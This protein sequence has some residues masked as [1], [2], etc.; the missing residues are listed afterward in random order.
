ML[1]LPN[2]LLLQI[3]AHSPSIYFNM[4]LTCKRIANIRNTEQYFIQISDNS[5]DQYEP[6]LM[7][8]RNANTQAFNYSHGASCYH[9]TCTYSYLPNGSLHSIN[10]V[11]ALYNSKHIHNWQDVTNTLITNAWYKHDMLHRVDNPAIIASVGD[12]LKLTAWYENGKL[13]RNNGPA[14]TINVNFGSTYNECYNLITNVI[15]NHWM[16]YEKNILGYIVEALMIENI[17]E[18]SVYY[19]DDIFIRSEVRCEPICERLYELPKY[20]LQEA[21]VDHDVAKNTI[22]DLTLEVP[23]A[24]A[25]VEKRECHNIYEYDQLSAGMKISGC[26]NIECNKS[27]NYLVALTLSK[28]Q[29]IQ[30]DESYRVVE[31]S[32]SITCN[33]NYQLDE[34]EDLLDIKGLITE[35]NGSRNVRI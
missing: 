28:T 2:E 11:P 7:A 8:S 29:N 27:E 31:Y 6:V 5:K 19:E 21:Y 35:F 18:L 17:H 20:T 9:Q 13:H 1:S 15:S 24:I 30:Y 10:D 4:I 32:D 14:I 25:S 34:H 23:F 16:V 22:R 26:R 33:D 12:I 3:G